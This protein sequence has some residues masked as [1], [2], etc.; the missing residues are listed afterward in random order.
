MGVLMDYNHENIDAEVKIKL[1]T[2]EKLENFWY[3]YKWHTIAGLFAVICIV[4]LTFQLC[5]KTSYDVNILYA[6]EKSISTSSLTGGRSQYLML[7]EDFE[8]VIDDFDNSGNVNVNLQKLYVLDVEQLKNALEGISDP[9]RKS[10]LEAAVQE[11]RN[12]FYNSL[13]YGGYYLCLL[14]ESLFFEYESMYEQSLFVNISDYVSDGVEYEYATEH[15]IYIGS[16]GIYALE[17][18]GTLP[19][20]TVVCLRKPG[21]LGQREESDDYKR[22]ESTLKS[23]LSYTK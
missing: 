13:M 22:A 21:A 11:D 3:H 23:I 17:T 6:G 7:T 20:N 10:Q 18:I 4:I 19:E 9:M 5:T 16:L 15:G 2:S 12:T 14:S 8:S 1:N